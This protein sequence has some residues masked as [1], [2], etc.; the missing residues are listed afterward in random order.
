MDRDIVRVFPR[1]VKGTED[2]MARTL[3]SEPSIFASPAAFSFRCCDSNR[4]NLDRLSKAKYIDFL[5][6]QAFVIKSIVPSARFATLRI[7]L[8]L[9]V[10][11]EI[12]IFRFG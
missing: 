6:Q 12:W 10:R 2:R 8:W 4:I 11:S 1:K 3:L 7:G 9:S 5:P